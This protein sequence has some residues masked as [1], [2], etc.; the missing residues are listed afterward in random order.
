V[1]VQEAIAAA[2]ARLEA[3]RIASPRVDAELLAAYV[4]AVPRGRLALVEVLSEGQRHH[5]EAI[6]RVRAQRVP[7]QYITGRAPFRNLDLAVGPGV[8]VPRPETEVVVEWGLRF[9]R[10]CAPGIVVDLC[11]GS[12]A[13]ALSVAGE[14]PEWSVY[15]VEFAESA[16]NF[17]RLNATGTGLTIVSGDA[18][19]PATLAELDGRVDLV[20]TNPPYVPEVG[21]A[22]LTPEV[23]R[24]D[25]HDAVFAGQDGLVVIRPLIDRIAGLLRPGGAFALEH[26]DTHAYVVPTLVAADGR[27]TGVELHHDLARRPRFTTAMRA[28]AQARMADWPA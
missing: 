25:P 26:D 17:L 15:A 12:G 20:L 8:F 14:A 16:M 21:A 1:R 11:A 10:A 27:F 22:G 3:A 24:H 28:P 4:L 9:L 23:S 5:Y 7:L 6:V 19:D 18:T 2:T 13:I